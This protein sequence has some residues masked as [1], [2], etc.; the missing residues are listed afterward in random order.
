MSIS[1]RGVSF[2]YDPGVSPLVVHD[3]DLE[4]ADGE[5][6]ARLGR[7]GCGK[8]TVARLSNGL[9]EPTS[10]TVLVEGYDTTDRASLPRVRAALQLVFQNPENQQ[11]G[12]TVFDDI[13]FG[14]ANLAVPTAQM[15][16]L[17]LIHI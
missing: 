7:N 4:V 2:S 5:Y 9:L 15:R 3:L 13:A 6:V 8:S 10:G 11:V 17:S 14:L 12:T 1:F 16:D